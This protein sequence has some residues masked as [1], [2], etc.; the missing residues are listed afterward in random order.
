M[1]GYVVINIYPGLPESV[2]IYG[3]YISVIITVPPFTLKNIL[4]YGHMY[5][6]KTHMSPLSP[7]S[8]I[9]TT[10]LS[11]CKFLVKPG[12]VFRILLK[13]SLQTAT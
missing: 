1:K 2:P 13:G 12:L 11:G 3:Y 10:K 9:Q 4:V 8:S 5:Q 7:P 6:S